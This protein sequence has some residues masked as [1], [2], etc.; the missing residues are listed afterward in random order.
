MRTNDHP[1][2][3][4]REKGVRLRLR[5]TEFGNLDPDTFRTSPLLHK[6]PLWYQLKLPCGRSNMWSLLVRAI[7]QLN[8]VSQTWRLAHLT[9]IRDGCHEGNAEQQEVSPQ[10]VKVSYV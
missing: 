6:V 1:F 3:S 7:V 8:W 10:R 5:Q 4:G 9:N 2:D